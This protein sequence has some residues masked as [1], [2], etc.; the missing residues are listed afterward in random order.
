VSEDQRRRTGTA[1]RESGK[2]KR[3]GDGDVRSGRLGGDV[4]GDSVDAGDLVG[5]TGGDLSKDGRGEVEPERKKRK[6]NQLH[7]SV[8]IHKKGGADDEAKRSGKGNSPIGSHKVIRSNSPQGDNLIVR[9]LV[10]SNTNGLDRQQ[11]GERLGDLVVEAGR[12][13]FF[14]VDS[15][16]FLE[17]GDLLAGDGAEDSDGETGS[18]ERMSANEVL[19]NFE[20]AAEGADLVC[21]WA[22]KKGK[23]GQGGYEVREGGG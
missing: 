13:D 7:Y 12:A 16:G 10:T 11:R 8:S 6:R 3:V 14:N 9:P 20:K 4:V 23:G 21:G 15:V 19:G 22:G 5:D 18:R 2:R 1:T 17:K